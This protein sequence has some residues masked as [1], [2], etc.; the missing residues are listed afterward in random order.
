[1]RIMSKGEITH[2]NQWGVRKILWAEG[3]GNLE[4]GTSQNLSYPYPYM[5]DI[6]YNF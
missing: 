6:A 4:S 2:V 5:S 1:M 3:N